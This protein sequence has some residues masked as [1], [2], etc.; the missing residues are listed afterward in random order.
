MWLKR[1]NQS[2]FRRLFAPLVWLAVVQILFFSLLASAPG[3]HEAAHGHAQDGD[4]I[5]LATDLS[6]GAVEGVLVLP[7]AAPEIAPLA[8]LAAAIRSAVPH[9]LPLHLAGSLLE[10]GPPGLALNP[11]NWITGTPFRSR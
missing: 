11:P 4:H 6:D 8:A 3:L 10:H 1:A 5:A 7:V 2:G 9:S